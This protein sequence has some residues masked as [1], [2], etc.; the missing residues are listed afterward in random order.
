MMPKVHRQ[1][2]LPYPPEALFDVVHRVEDY[3]VFV[4]H[5][6]DVVVTPVAENELIARVQ[7]DS[8]A[9]GGFFAT[10]NRW[11]RPH[12]LKMQLEEG[13]LS[14]LQGQ[15]RFEAV[16]DSGCRVT[17]DLDFD[18]ANRLIGLAFSRV[19][20]HLVGQLFDAFV[21]RSREVCSDKQ[22]S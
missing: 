12:W 21:Q 9:L 20:G 22:N 17:L 18:F 1:A 5:I 19:F 10:R 7:L 4:P 16:G 14:Y 6:R 11:E 8:A 3:P 2:L 13:P 15:W